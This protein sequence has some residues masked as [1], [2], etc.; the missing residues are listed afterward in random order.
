MLKPLLFSAVLALALPAQAQWTNDILLNTPV[1][2]ATGTAEEAP[3]SAPG[4]AGG[5]W[6]SWFAT[7][8]STN[9]TMHLQLLDRNGNKLLGPNGLLVSNQ[10]Q[11]TATFRYDLKSDAAGNALL[12]FQD[13]RSGAMQCVIYKVSPTGQ[14][15]WGANGIPLLDPA[16]GSGLAPTIGV[17]PSGNVVVAWN[18][19]SN[20]G[21]PA[22]AWQKFSPA[23]TPA[24]P[25]PQRIVDATASSERAIP[26]PATG[27]EFIMHFVRRSGFGLG[28]STYFAQRYDAAGAAVWAT[29]VQVST[30]TTGFAYF[31]E[32]VS[33]GAG[34]YFLAFNTGNPANA[35]LGDVYVQHVT[36]T[37]ALWNPE[38]VE[39]ITGTA[40]ARFE[41]KL[42][43]VAAQSQLYVG[44]NATNSSQSDSGIFFQSL[45][46][47]TGNRLLTNAGVQVMPVSGRYYAVQ[48][49]RDTGNGLIV[50]Y[51]E[52]TTILERWL[53]S[54]KVTYTGGTHAFPTG[55]GIIAL[56]N[57]NSEKQ[58]YSVPPFASNQL[59][60][61]WSDSRLDG[62]IYAQSLD[63][64]GQLGVLAA[65]ATAAARPL[66]L[67]PNPGSAPTLQ[68]E[69]ARPG[70]VLVRD[71]AGRV[72]HQQAVSAGPTQ[73]N[74]PQ[75]AAGVYVVEAR[76][77]S[78]TWRGRWVK[79]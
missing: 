7:S 17:L 65:R 21:K 40:T 79:E 22:V 78:E 26:V 61:V 54:T 31:A 57:V 73:L 41:G 1:Q 72:V 76:L 10:P 68:L 37:G 64:N 43:Y 19:D 28:V 27:D 11:T 66:T 13:Q 45:D 32:P 63:D 52:N 67:L 46:P 3:L 53:T 70:T 33:D 39:V 24:W 30:K 74:A 60:I 38:G 55:S 51:S 77:G 69:A 12:A 49:L 71:L 62:G 20:V 29:P 35:N 25:A 59:V 4:P 23:G 2:D 44:L 16:A 6:V 50:I 47:A 56:S 75:L 36:A 58:D 48:A 15:L 14:Q 8:P 18:S 34:G 5:T 9:Y 42:Q